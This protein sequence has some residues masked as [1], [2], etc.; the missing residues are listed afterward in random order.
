MRRLVLALPLPLLAA[1][2]TVGPD[3]HR[4]A[5]V[6]ENA[7]W[8]TPANSAEADLAPWAKLHDPVLSA[9]IDKAIVANLDIVEAEAKLREARAQRGVTR[10]KGLPSATLKGSAQQ[11]Q[12]SLVGQ[13][14][15]ENI[16]FYDRNFSLF[17]AGF[18][19][20]WEIDLWGGQRR[21]VQAADRQIDAARARA[22]DVRLQTV[23][24]VV[25][26]YAQLRGSQ[27]SLAAARTDAQAQSETARIVRQRFRAGE[28]ARFDDS[29]A[30]EQARTAAAAIPDLEADIRTAGFKLA[31][32]TGR[33]P[34][35]RS[36]S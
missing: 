19:A 13:F 10:A 26:T 32:L 9:L 21:A 22:I 23:A 18:D 29:R 16:P 24:E 36:P 4:P 27:A 14:P 28:A 2:C 15:A 5:T 8:V 11:T 7:A 17:E 20:S 3:Y 31:L 25:R 1:A 33:A 12:T 30:E 35:K 6:G 34:G